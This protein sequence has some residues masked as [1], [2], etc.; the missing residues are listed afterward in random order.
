[1]KI[2]QLTYLVKRTDITDRYLYG[3]RRGTNRANTVFIEIL[4]TMIVLLRIDQ[5]QTVCLNN[6]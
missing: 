5:L 1:M 4:T 6:K 2:D 3:E